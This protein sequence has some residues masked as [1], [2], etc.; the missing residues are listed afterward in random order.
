MT[1]A[2]C[3]LQAL[4][5]A[6]ATAL[7]AG[8]AST[9]N[10]AEAMARQTEAQIELARKNVPSAEF[11]CRDLTQLDLPDETF[12]AICSYYAIIHIPR[13][14]HE[15][16]LV[17]FYRLLKPA[18]SVLLCLGAENL[19]DDVDDNFLG[20]PMYWSHFDGETYLEMLRRIGFHVIWS[21]YVPDA[22]CEGAGHL[23]VL[24]QKPS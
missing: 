19:V 14:E 20:A 3:R 11:I 22:G 15:P 17:N 7:L 6:T 13:A 16:L 10:S 5:L 24:A 9:P 18:G 8:C 2:T 12:D 4:A 21:K 1:T 23:F